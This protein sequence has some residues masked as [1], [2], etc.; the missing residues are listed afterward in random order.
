ME[1]GWME[2][3]GDGWSSFSLSAP[4][5]ISFTAVVQDTLLIINQHDKRVPAA[6]EPERPGS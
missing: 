5:L 6:A 4:S 1:D 3:D 2:P